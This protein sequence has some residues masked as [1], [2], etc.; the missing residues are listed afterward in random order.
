MDSENIYSYLVAILTSKAQ[1]CL[2]SILI[3]SGSDESFLYVMHLKMHASVGSKAGGVIVTTTNNEDMHDK[4]TDNN[5][6]SVLALLYSRQ[7]FSKSKI[8]G[9]N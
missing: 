4:S 1:P 7:S 3:S 5:I 2:R 6:G 8:A 9:I